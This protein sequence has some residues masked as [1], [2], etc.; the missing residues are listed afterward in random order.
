MFENIF[1]FAFVSA[2]SLHVS[3]GKEL[4]LMKSAA[5]SY[6]TFGVCFMLQIV[7]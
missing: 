5:Q 4:K 1:G 7:T 6:V 2:W 3:Y